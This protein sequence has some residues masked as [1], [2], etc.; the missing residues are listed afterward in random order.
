MKSY[1]NATFGKYKIPG[2]ILLIAGASLL[3]WTLAA[4]LSSSMS[5]HQHSKKNVN[6]EN[7]EKEDLEAAT[8]NKRVAGPLNL[9]SS[10]SPPLD[11]DHASLASLGKLTPLSEE[12][13]SLELEIDK[14][15]K[16]I[17]KRIDF[18]DRLV[19]EGSRSSKVGH[20]IRAV[21]QYNLVLEQDS[22]NS[23]AL[24]ALARIS[25]ESGAFDNSMAYFKKYLVQKPN[26]KLAKNDLA[27]AELQTGNVDAAINRLEQICIEDPNY[28]ESHLAL[29]LAYRTKNDFKKANLLADKSLKL[30]KSIKQHG[31]AETLLAA[32]SQPQTQRALAASNTP[33]PS[34]SIQSY[35][36][37][38]QIIGPKLKKIVWKTEDQVHLVLE[39]FPIAAMPEV[40]KSTFLA[41]AK[42]ALKNIGA[43]INISIY[44]G[45][46]PD[47]KLELQVGEG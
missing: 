24:L 2:F 20:I 3:L 44:D 32:L 30:A 23:S 12:L 25:Y 29:A 1:K 13:K 8:M 39:D 17:A 41:K 37:E 36:S 14:N 9:D 42:S 18:A 5:T 15:P 38:H 31:A 40:A 43:V 6:S 16:N 47:R 27:L 35:F 4:F 10:V 19:S 26:D 33:S 34:G 7:L 11:A 28:F 21:E 22:K 46:I 45:K